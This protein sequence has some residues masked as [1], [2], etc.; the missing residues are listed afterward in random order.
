MF[1]HDLLAIVLAAL[2]AFMVGGLWYSPLAF[3]Q[4]WLEG[5]GLTQRDIN[6]A[7]PLKVY[8]GAFIFALLAAIAFAWL[9]GIPHNVGIAV[10]TGFLV[11][12]GFAFTSFGINYLFEQKPMKL[13][14]VNG[15]YHVL[16]F[17]IMGAVLGLMA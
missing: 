14:W 5:C 4:A 16:Q 7:H 11:G 17:T 1:G 13:L 2:S 3:Q 12:S 6:D 8:G 9:L 10:G 15:G